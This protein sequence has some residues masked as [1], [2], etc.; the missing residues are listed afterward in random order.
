ML[1]E[2]SF[3]LGMWPRKLKLIRIDKGLN[4]EIISGTELDDFSC[5]QGRAGAC[6][7]SG[8]CTKVYELVAGELFCI[9]ANVPLSWLIVDIGILELLQLSTRVY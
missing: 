6:Y 4:P 3:R 7:S 1:E 5:F 8:R 9:F 2:V